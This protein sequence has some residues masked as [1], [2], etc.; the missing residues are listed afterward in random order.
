[1]KKIII[2]GASS[3]I[4]RAL[5]CHYHREGYNVGVT[6]RR[7]QRLKE[8][9]SSLGE[10]RMT[11]RFMD[12]ADLENSAAVFKELVQSM[13]GCDI[14]IYNAGVDSGGGNWNAAS[15][16]K[17]ISINSL[18][19]V[20]IA[21]AS[22][23]HFRASGGGHFVCIS[24]IA[25]LRGN[26]RSPA[27]SASKAMVSNYLAGIRQRLLGSSIAVTDIRPGYVM[28]EMIK[29]R[30]K[31]FWAA[32]P[33]KAASQIASAIQKK[34]K[35]AYVTHRWGIIAFLIPMIPQCLYDWGFKK[36]F[37]KKNA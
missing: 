17:T 28:T 3:G 26:G 21:H 10:P 34:K 7:V 1:M 24:S 29:D 13:G 9:A 11:Y 32:T 20:A 30:S 31:A 22:I 23:E 15:D 12:V 25:G 33:E 16:L 19:V 37:L 18:G 35:M 5:A 6:A 36:Y 8:L 2:I 14:V 4:G 27:Y